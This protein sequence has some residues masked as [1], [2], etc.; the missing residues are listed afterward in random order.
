LGG[1]DI[2]NCL[3]HVVATLFATTTGI[4]TIDKRYLDKAATLE[5]KGFKKLF[6]VI[7]PAASPNILDGFAN[8]L[9][10]AFVLLVF[11][12]MFGRNAGM[13]LFVRLN[14]EFGLCNPH[15]GRLHIYG[16]C[17]IHGDTAF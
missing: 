16:D 4:V 2:L 13:G 5:I 3:W 10:Q 14:T 15:L 6:R 17:A 1:F 7:L 11:A 8:S 9:R 12:E